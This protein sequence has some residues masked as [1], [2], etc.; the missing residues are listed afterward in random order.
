MHELPVVRVSSRIDGYKDQGLLA[1]GASWC[2]WPLGYSSVAVSVQVHLA[3]RHPPPTAAH[4]NY[5]SQIC[6]PEQVLQGMVRRPVV[7]LV[8]G[9]RWEKGR[10]Q[11]RGGGARSGRRGRS[12]SC[13]CLLGL[14]VH[15]GQGGLGLLADCSAIVPPDIAAHQHL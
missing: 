1:P 3:H 13:D 5:R 6:G 2:V 11:G 15:P 4:S 9:Q 8:K 10:P 7:V 14:C 12:A